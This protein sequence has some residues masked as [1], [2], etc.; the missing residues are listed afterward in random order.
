MLWHTPVIHINIY[1]FHQQICAYLGNILLFV[2]ML[3]CYKINK[4][5]RY[6]H[7]ETRNTN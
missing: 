5:K 4:T 6:L 3:L 2:W 1:N 7:F